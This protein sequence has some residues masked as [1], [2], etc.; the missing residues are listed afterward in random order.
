MDQETLA[1]WKAMQDGFASLSGLSLLSFDPQRTLVWAPSQ[2]NPICAA[3]QCT[4]VGERHCQAHCGKAVAM[5]VETAKPAFL[6]CEANLH[7]FTVPIVVEGKVTL[8]LQG[9]KRFI[10][11]EERIPTERLTDRTNLPEETFVA[12][13]KDQAPVTMRGFWL[14]P[15]TWNR[16]PA[17]CSRAGIRAPRSD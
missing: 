10:A 14:P 1:A 9:G 16:R 4:D 6:K 17:C 12:L 15:G 2:D 8:I 7:V 5:A 11:E 13:A 3:V